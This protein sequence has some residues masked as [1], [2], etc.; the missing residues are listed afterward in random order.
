MRPHVKAGGR[1]R[2]DEGQIVVDSIMSIR[3]ADITR[4]LARESGFSSVK[5]LLQTAKHGG[6]HNV[7]LIR[8]VTCPRVLGMYS[9]RRARIAPKDPPNQAPHSRQI[10][11]AI[12]SSYPEQQ[13][14]AVN[15]E[16]QGRPD[17]TLKP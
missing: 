12:T 4:D 8:F 11:V 17:H 3:L 13:A 15:Q 5:E 10:Q 14:E 2:M 7:Y 9:A 6:G 16:G 1:Y